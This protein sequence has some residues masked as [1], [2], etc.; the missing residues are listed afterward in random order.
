MRTEILPSKITVK[1]EVYRPWFKSRPNHTDGRGVRDY[2][3]HPSDD[4]LHFTRHVN[5]LSRTE[6]IKRQWMDKTGKRTPY[7]FASM[8]E[9]PPRYLQAHEN[10]DGQYPSYRPLAGP[11]GGQYQNHPNTFHR[12][13]E[14]DLGTTYNHD[15]NKRHGARNAN[16][17]LNLKEPL[18]ISTSSGPGAGYGINNG[19]L[20]GVN[21]MAPNKD[22]QWL[23]TQKDHYRP[24]P[25]NKAVCCLDINPNERC[26]FC[27]AADEHA[28]AEGKDSSCSV[29]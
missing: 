8:Q 19:S 11:L 26:G 21:W 29:N 22:G 10:A 28:A 20:G 23:T 24:L 1:E 15:Y 3:T 9:I 6:D 4:S 7:K 5:S 17:F 25:L 13:V 12:G 2:Y 27:E 14:D 16:Q 18:A